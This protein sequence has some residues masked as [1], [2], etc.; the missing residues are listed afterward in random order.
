[1][2]RERK[3]MRGRRVRAERVARRGR[4]GP[5]EPERVARDGIAIGRHVVEGIVRIVTRR[6]KAAR[7]RRNE[8]QCTR[9]FVT[10][11]VIRVVGS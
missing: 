5:V 6:P 3:D 11:R 4:G 10:V 2:V 8:G 9:D 7:G 1:M